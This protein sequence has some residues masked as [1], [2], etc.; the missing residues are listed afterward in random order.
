[1]KRFLIFISFIFLFISCCITSFEFHSDFNPHVK[2][3]QQINA[4]CQSVEKT[5]INTD[6][7]IAGCAQI[8]LSQ[9][10]SNLFGDF[11]AASENAAY[12]KLNLY[13]VFTHWQNHKLNACKISYLL[14][15]R[16]P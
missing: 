5:D 6:Y 2:S 1:M 15:P 12:K 13:T 9:Y 7:Y 11:Y 3:M 10:L 4:A 14:N 16:G 8:N